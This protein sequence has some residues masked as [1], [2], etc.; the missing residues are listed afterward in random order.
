MTT[1]ESMSKSSGNL[2]GIEKEITDL[3]SWPNVLD[4][5]E[6]IHFYFVTPSPYLFGEGSITPSP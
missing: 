3:T 5:K 4:R 2:E 1:H 6:N